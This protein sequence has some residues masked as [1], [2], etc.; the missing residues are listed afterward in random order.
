MVPAAALVPGTVHLLRPELNPVYAQLADAIQELGD[1]FAAQGIRRIVYYSTQWISVLGHLYQAKADLRGLHV[2]ENW[3]E[4]AD[5]PFAFRVD[6]PLAVALAHEAERDGYQTRLVDYE[7]FPVDTGTIV[8][9]R[10]LNQGRF[11]TAMVS[12]CVYSDYADTVK[13]AQTAARAIAA[14]GVP[15]A[16]VAVSLLS[17]RYFT[18][19]IDWREDGV[20]SPTDDQLNRQLLAHLESGR[21]DAAEALIPELARVAK[22]DMGLKALAFLKGTGALAVGRRARTMAYGGLYGTGAA[23]VAF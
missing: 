12:C 11:T 19:E 2:D 20:A 9:D 23:V 3:Y 22:A 1:H 16:V 10:L 5:L 18:T 7:G 6:R 17:G 4:L 21:L 13:L 8:V 14:D 15:T